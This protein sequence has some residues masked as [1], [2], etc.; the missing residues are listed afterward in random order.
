MIDMVIAIL[1]V[2]VSVILSFFLI[3]RL[4]INRTKNIG[5]A[6][7]FYSGLILI[8]VATL[9]NLISKHPE[10]ITWFLPGVYPIISSLLAIFFI[11]GSILAIIGLTLHFSYWDDR[12]FEVSNHLD[13]L[14]LIDNIQQD[15]HYPY[16]ML[17]LLD[18]VLKN[19]LGGLGE[20]AGAIFLLDN[21]KRKFILA[22]SSGLSR[23]E[24]SLLEYYPYERNIVTQAI[25]DQTPLITSDFRSLGG[26]A[27]L[28]ASNFHS[29][30]IIP[31]LSGK[32]RLGAILL[33]S[34]EERH[35]TKEQLSIIGPISEWLSEKIEVNRLNREISKDRRN[36]EKKSEQLTALSSRLKQI[37]SI[38]SEIPTPSEFIE[39]TTGLFG[40]S[41]AWLIGLNAGRMTIYGGTGGENEFSDSYKSALVN[42]LNRKKAVILNQEGTS[43]EGQSYISRSSLLFP[44]GNSNAILL[45]RTD[46]V[47]SVT[48]DDLLVLEIIARIGSMVIANA[49]TGLIS[50][51]RGRGVKLI[52]DI[53]QQKIT[54]TRHDKIVG[55]LLSKIGEMLTD[56][57]I[58]A[59]FKR[60]RDNYKQIYDSLESDLSEAIIISAGEGSTGKS[61]A[62]R[63]EAALFNS[64]EISDNV[65][66]YSD[67]NR[68]KLLH[69]FGE[70]S[71][72]AYHGDFPII[73]KDQ[74]EF[75]VT[76]FGFNNSPMENMEWHRLLSLLFNLLNLRFEI[77]LGELGDRRLETVKTVT[78]SQLIEQIGNLN[79][80]LAEI[81]GHCQLA[82]Q[83]PNLSGG[84]DRM[85]ESILSKVDESAGIIN[86]LT[87][88]GDEKISTVPDSINLK[89][90]I[91][92]FFNENRISGNLHMVDGRP[93][94]VE[95]QLAET[96]PINVDGKKATELIYTACRIIAEKMSNKDSLLVANYKDSIYLYLDIVKRSNEYSFSEKVSEFGLYA[97]PESY[98]GKQ[99]ASELLKLTAILSAELA[100]D[101]QNPIPA[102]YSFR[103]KPNNIGNINVTTVT[104]KESSILAV[105]D[106]AIILDLLAAM[107]QSL[108][109][110]IYTAKNGQEGLRLFEMFRPDIVISD[111]AMPV[112]S[113][114]EL[115]SQIKSISPGT[116]I[117][118]IT[119]WGVSVD[120]ERMAKIGVD[121]ILYKPF[122]LEQ[123]SDIIQ[124]VRPS[125]II[126]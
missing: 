122:R 61:A 34:P 116:P 115:A 99:V 15:S 35:Y 90:A 93:I 94:T 7:F 11:G 91:E 50:H 117:I 123:L 98:A 29:I 80:N 124:Q 17:E 27:Q 126:Q 105:D 68:E 106:Q 113:G 89:K 75:V 83:D 57:F 86:S 102:F 32:N 16:P 77:S 69:L 92:D 84:L 14:R 6:G 9:I 73:I 66:E 96:P 28:A 64:K 85:L 53:L 48:D 76:V 56:N 58:I 100:V 49:K 55:S 87:I 97:P 8:F 3:S 62:L 25:E 70:R 51:S 119:G 103:F 118:I 60:D 20:E 36:L 79:N 112:M 1:Y 67:S 109:Y 63:T 121:H 101:N 95:S 46:G 40:A 71:T 82:R 107:G 37:V 114:W 52:S 65:S 24:I 2:V 12:D 59:L 104:E 5:S 31:L 44:A 23:E 30:L 111:L 10:Y 45:R 13:K 38:S 22:T 18:R 54:K 42:A 78:S 26:K 47:F 81:S 43:A 19:M 21:T 41:D 125:K 33:F 110:K 74:T 120:K 4:K 39:K 72:P 108:G 88:V